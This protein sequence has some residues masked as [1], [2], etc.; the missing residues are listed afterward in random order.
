MDA[1]P[2]AVGEVHAFC[3]DARGDAPVAVPVSP[4][5][6]LEPPID[7]NHAALG[8]VL[9]DKG[10]GPSPA[11]HVEEIRATLPVRRFVVTVNGDA[12]ATYRDAVLGVAEL[13]VPDQTAH[14]GDVIQHDF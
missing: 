6:G 2:P 13:G 9:A 1:V 11:H 10:G 7:G 12:E 5:L 4:V 8:E 3:D 14:D